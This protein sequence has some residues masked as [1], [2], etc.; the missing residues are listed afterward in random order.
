MWGRERMKQTI[1]GKAM[2]IKRE[3][4][5]P[6]DDTASKGLEKEAYS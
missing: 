3:A 4:K 5:E 6:R 1:I 2:K